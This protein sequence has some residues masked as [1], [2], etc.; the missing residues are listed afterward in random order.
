M[1]E[2]NSEV[3]EVNNEGKLEPNEPTV[4]MH[5]NTQSSNLYK[6]SDNETV[7]SENPEYARKPRRVQESKNSMIFV[8]ALIILGFIFTF[9]V[10]YLI[11]NLLFR[12]IF[13]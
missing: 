1:N 2:F 3:N 13:R 8:V 10:G 9:G 12:F 7:R 5:T 6:Y 11:L 4:N